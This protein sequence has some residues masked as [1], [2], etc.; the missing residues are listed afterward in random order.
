MPET[1]T[2]TIDDEHADEPI[3]YAIGLVVAFI[4]EEQGLEAA[5]FRRF[6]TRL[7]GHRLYRVVDVTNLTQ[8]EW[9]NVKLWRY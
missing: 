4:V 3:R 7:I 2:V 1:W 8:E 9:N 6:E 5:R